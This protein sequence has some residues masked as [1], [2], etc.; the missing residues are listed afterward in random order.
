M[1]HDARIVPLDRRDHIPDGVRQWMGDS[2]GYWD[3]DTLVVE[4][5]NFSDKTASFNP[6]VA[7]AVGSG[8]TL[9]LT[10]RFRRVDADTLLYEVHRR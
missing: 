5:R 4:T 6:S 1:V 8:D 10:E 3:G 9:H 2:R 7:T